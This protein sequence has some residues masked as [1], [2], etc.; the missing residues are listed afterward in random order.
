MDG[1]EFHWPF[2]PLG[3][4]DTFRVWWHS[5]SGAQKVRFWHQK[6]WIH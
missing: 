3:V 1:I 5:P 2:D 4:Y 6:G